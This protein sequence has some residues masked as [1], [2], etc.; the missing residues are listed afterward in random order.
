MRYALSLALATLAIGGAVAA[1]QSQ[2]S[3][4]YGA[5]GGAYGIGSPRDYLM[6]STFFSSGGIVLP[7]GVSGL[8][9]LGFNGVWG[10]FLAGIELAGRLGQEN[11]TR[12]QFQ[13]WG[14]FGAGR[15][16]ASTTQTFRYSSGAG[17]HLSAR[18]GLIF[19]DILLFG[20]IGVGFSR[21]HQSY[22]DASS[23]IFCPSIIDG[24]RPISPGGTASSSALLPSFLIGVGAEQNFGSWFL[25]GGV[26]AEAISG[27]YK[28]NVLGPTIS[29]STQFSA[30]T[31]WTVRGNLMLGVRF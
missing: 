20:K 6:Q 31:D 1:D 21:V 19:N 7:H 25:R 4:L 9:A 26:D 29:G 2:F 14:F 15:N 12:S 28:L 3:G 17:A 30:P 8:T 11:V 18:A 27:P 16:T 5:A 13:D 10:S 22:S 23:G 24:C